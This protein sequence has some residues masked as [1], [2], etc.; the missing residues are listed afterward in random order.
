[1]PC[2]SRH[3]RLTTALDTVVPWV[4]PVCH[5]VQVMTERG[6]RCGVSCTFDV[7]RSR[8]ASRSGVALSSV[9]F[10]TE[11]FM[12]ATVLSNTSL[13]LMLCLI[14][15]SMRVS[16]DAAL[17]SLLRVSTSIV[18]DCVG[19]SM[20]GQCLQPQTPLTP[21]CHRRP[22]IGQTVAER[23]SFT[24][25]I[26]VTGIARTCTEHWIA[27][28]RWTPSSHSL[29]LCSRGCHLQHPVPRGKRSC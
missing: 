29:S 15:C 19:L 5:G 26:P 8:L 4:P 17:A 1:M 9:D 20:S 22:Q 12:M 11:S 6:T 2:T 7:L 23:I 18:P 16:S 27:F 13:V 3:P 28:Q 24:T 25:L 14:N 21:F 10:V